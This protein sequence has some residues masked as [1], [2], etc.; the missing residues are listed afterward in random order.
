VLTLLVVIALPVGLAFL[1]LAG[2]LE[3]RTFIRR[4]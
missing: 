1:L 3:D 2:V 4:R